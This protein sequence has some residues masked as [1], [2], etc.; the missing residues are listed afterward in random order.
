MR[1]ESGAQSTRA[2]SP[3]EPIS[4]ASDKSAAESFVPGLTIC[5]PRSFVAALYSH[6]LSGAIRSGVGAAVGAGVGRA[7]GAVVGD[8]SG[9]LSLPIIALSSAM[10]FRVNNVIAP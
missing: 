8:G 9:G 7:V 1:L 6:L 5:G 3:H 2:L 4:H 10:R